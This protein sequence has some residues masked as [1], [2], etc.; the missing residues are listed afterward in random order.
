MKRFAL[1]GAAGYI[2]PRHMKAIK[3]TGNEIVT[4]LDKSDS[5]GI[6]DSYFPKADFFTEFERFDRHLERLRRQ[7]DQKVD[8]VSIC[9]PNY[10]HDSHVRF[11]LRIGADAICEKPIVLNPWNIDALAEI[12]ERTK[13]NVYTI[14]QLRLHPAVRTLKNRVD[15]LPKD[16]RF[17]VDISY[18]TPRGHWYMASWKG[19]ASKS[20]GVTTN[21]GVHL[22][23]MVHWIFG[24]VKESVIHLSEP[25]RAA[26]VLE[27]DR[28][29]VKWFLSL[30]EMDLPPAAKL[31]KTKTLRSITV[32]GQELD[33]SE[34]FTDLH[35]DSY[36]AILKGKGFGLEDARASVEIV[37]HIRSAEPVGF[38]GD[39]HPAIQ[40][41][42]NG[43]G[44]DCPVSKNTLIDDIAYAFGDI[45]S[46]QQRATVTTALCHN[47]DILPTNQRM[48]TSRVKSAR[49]QESGIFHI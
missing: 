27:L 42:A 46:C 38:K 35:T 30:D 23:D 37:S 8:Y 43:N 48:W 14:L 39:Y 45:Q 4:V 47:K 15:T 6:I 16:R 1:I 18:V 9:S 32:D 40:N 41:W 20:G 34:G 13:K 5:V 19:D 25:T 2:A 31:G 10:L 11:A 44:P 21:I 28:A 36:K 33:F 26:G 7:G 49:G 22:F 12:S 29:R 3:D 24:E 17:D